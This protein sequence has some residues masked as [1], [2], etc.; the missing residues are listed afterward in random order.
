MINFFSKNKIIFYLTNL[1]FII[2]YIFPGSLLGCIFKDDCDTQPKLTSDFH[3]I[4][5]NHFYIFLVIS[6]VGFFTYRKN[7]IKYLISYLLCLSIF[8]E[9]THLVIPV[10]NFQW[11]D[12]IGNLLGV[13]IVIFVNNLMNKYGFFKK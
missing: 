3:F 6:L 13:I 12:L 8:L 2:L 9:L 5:S 7:E 11:E 10:R 1:F 4:S